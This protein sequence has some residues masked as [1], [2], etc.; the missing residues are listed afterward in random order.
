MRLLQKSAAASAWIGCVGVG[1]V[2]HGQTLPT[3]AVA[4]TGLT[5][6][7]HPSNPSAYQRVDADYGIVSDG[8]G[9]HV[10]AFS[11]TTAVEYGPGPY[12]HG[13]WLDAGTGR[14]VQLAA[15]DL[16]RAVGSPST[17]Y[18]GGTLVVDAAGGLAFS[19]VDLGLST[20]PP[21]GTLTNL[22]G[23]TGP[24]PGTAET[25]GLPGQVSIDA[26]GTTAL[27][28]LLDPSGAAVYTTAWAN[29]TTA[30]GTTGVPV[31][32]VMVSGGA[33]PAGG[34]YAS[35]AGTLRFDGG[36]VFTTDTATYAGTGGTT[37]TL[38][39][40]IASTAAGDRLLARQGDPAAGLPGY[41]YAG[42]PGPP[43][44]NAAGAVAFEY[45]VASSTRNIDE[46]FV[47]AGT[48]PRPVF[49]LGQAAP[50]TGGTF[51]G[52][53]QLCLNDAGLLLFD[54]TVSGGTATAGLWEANAAGG[55]QPVALA[56]AAAPGV[57]AGYAF[58]NQFA[59]PALSD[60][61]Q[62]A[63]EATL[64]KAGSPNL[65]ALFAQDPSAPGGVDLIAYVGEPF[66]V[67][68]GLANGTISSIG[69]APQSY[70][71]QSF[72][73]DTLAYQLG[74]ADGRS[75]LYTTT[76]AT[77]EPAAAGVVG[78]AVALLGRRRRQRLGK[79]GREVR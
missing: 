42:S 57:P 54:G 31:T 53:S 3:V 75:G 9:G 78:S 74:F 21:N 72:A 29:A 61:G 30:A 34:T 49:A 50:V 8:A 69:F 40:A 68:P 52:Y 27:K 5:A 38:S 66:A 65:T 26:N 39:V 60:D 58:T 24:A 47:D 70:A 43:T 41:T 36:A 28:V 63:F 17:L 4:A 71:Q 59:D 22:I 44:A 56:G 55:I 25:I 12:D 73:G 77:P 20:L 18:A 51:N 2:A 46:V 16:D 10:L 23:G 48:G 76:V 13:I 64:A 15:F 32:L 7:G 62:A 19:D 45:R 79:P 11:A 1:V 33:A 67:G 14:G 37:T 35:V 6:P